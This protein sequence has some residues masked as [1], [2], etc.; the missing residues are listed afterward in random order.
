LVLAA[1]AAQI[2]IGISMVVRG[3]PLWLATAHNGG[4]ALTLLAVLALVHSLRAQPLTAATPR[5]GAV[6]PAET[7]RSAA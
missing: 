4:A 3:F 5:W 6:E 1:L 2:T 7:P